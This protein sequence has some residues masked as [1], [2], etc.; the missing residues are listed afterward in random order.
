MDRWHGPGLLV[1]TLLVAA[2]TASAQT[3]FAMQGLGQNVRTGT[4]RDTGRGGWGMA[5][6]D[7][8]VPGTL[9]P[10]ALA[11]LRFAGLVFSGYGELTASE[12]R[13]QE[14]STSRT[15]LPNVR[16]AAPLRAGRLALH[17]GF[18]VRRSLQW[19]SRTERDFQHAGREV[20]GWRDYDREGTL[21]A[22]PVGL[23]WRASESLALGV[24]ANL[25]RGSIDE[26]VT[27]VLGDSLGSF[28]TNTREQSDELTGHNLML[29]LLWRPWSRLQLGASYTTAYD[30]EFAREVSLG[31][32]GA[33][34][35]EELTASMP[36]EYRV[37]LQYDLGAAWRFGADGQLARYSELT[38]R[39]QWD[40]YLRD[41]W[42]VAAG[43]ERLLQRDARGRGFRPPLRFGFQWRHWAHAV[44]G[45]PV[46]ER[47]ISVGTGF[48]FRDRLGMI[49]LSLSYAWIGDEQD[50]GYASQSWRLGVSITGLERLVF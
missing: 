29:S 38:G 21:F 47:V 7:T 20:V 30:L 9:N 12:G 15:Y 37:G 8:L 39:P 35:G 43:F 46:H 6:A 36:A 50:N 16:V 41:E 44:G 48:P 40:P 32:V 23:S 49:D 31:G 17:A 24:T 2:A 27:E 3:P 22:M 45:P 1:L 19:D 5:D 34:F 33:R 4:A 26:V 13:G 10:A 18:D 14:R 25:V 28:A 42:T 11:D